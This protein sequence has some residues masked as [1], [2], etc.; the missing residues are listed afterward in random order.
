[1]NALHWLAGLIVLA[2]ALNKLERACPLRA[3]LSP[4][5]RLVEWLK[6]LGWT[7]LAM[8]AGAAVFL[9]LLAAGGY[10]QW[11]R[12]LTD[13]AVLIGF[14]LLIIRTRVR[15]GLMPRARRQEDKAS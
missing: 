3:G 2:E 4:R 7:A 14:A 6:T 5:L 12:Q 1:M 10:L 8:G 13:T 15:E 11:L 9:P